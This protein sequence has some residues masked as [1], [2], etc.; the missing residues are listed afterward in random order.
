[1]KTGTGTGAGM[2]LGFPLRVTSR[3]GVSLVDLVLP[4]HYL[5]LYTPSLS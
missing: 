5:L 4:L 3:F 1:M 2:G